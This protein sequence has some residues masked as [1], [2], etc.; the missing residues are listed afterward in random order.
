M[1]TFSWNILILTTISVLMY[2]RRNCVFLF[3][4]MNKRKSGKSNELDTAIIASTRSNETTIWIGTWL[5]LMAIYLLWKNLME[6][7]LFFV[8][9]ILLKLALCHK[10]H[11]TVNTVLFLFKCLQSIIRK[12]YL[13]LGVFLIPYCVCASACK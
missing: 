2:R 12:L 11:L 13:A 8:K 3:A 7:R 10:S 4:Q 6:L 9:N 1:I 5:F